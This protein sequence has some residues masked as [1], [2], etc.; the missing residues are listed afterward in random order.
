MNI[1]KFNPLSGMHQRELVAVSFSEDS[2]KLALVK[3]SPVKKELVY[4]ASR[5]T[6]GMSDNDII[7]L[8]SSSFD[9]MGVNC[10]DVVVVIP[11][12]M[13]ITKNIEIPS[14]DP[15]EI[16]EIIN[17]QAGR[18]TPY[19]REEIIVDYINIGTFKHSY[20]KAL[21]VIVAKSAVK[22][23]F[24]II[25]RSG[26]EPGKVFLASEGMAWSAQKLFKTET[27]SAPVGMVHVDE[28]CSDFTVVYKNKPIFVRNISIG[29]RHL[30]EEKE[31]YQ[32]RLIEELKITREAYQSEDI[33]QNPQSIVLTGA[34]EEMDFLQSALS[35]ALAVPVRTMPYFKNIALGGAAKKLPASAKKVSFLDIIAPL[36]AWEWMKVDLIPEEVKVRKS[37][38]ERAKHLMKTGIYS[39]TIVVLFFFIFISK[40]YVKGEYLKKL[41]NKYGGINIEARELEESFGK[42]TLIRNFQARRGYSLGVLSEMYDMIPP[43]IELNYIRF[44]D[45]GK[46]SIRGTAKS[47]STVFSFVDRLKRSEYFS[48]VETRYTTKRKEELKDVVDFE[49]SSMIA[50]IGNKI[51]AS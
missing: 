18:H 42:I 37:I 51:E 8:I 7:D 41:E 24:D 32:L 49:I 9:E 33:E 5:K 25:F 3:V 46:F 39:L 13:V 2:L 34:V 10:P 31:K 1:L 30:T 36:L 35:L 40:I 45:Q 48:V 43:D 28:E 17:L 50:N 19:T 4:F 15:G 12:H 44:D 22:K 20:T 21:L 38:E 47:M 11:T 23:Q 16:Q 26:F 29:A 27:Q 14:T 6:S